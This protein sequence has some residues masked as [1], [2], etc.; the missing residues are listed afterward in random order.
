MCERV[1]KQSRSA[2]LFLRRKQETKLLLWVQKLNLYIC[3]CGIV[4]CGHFLGAEILSP[5]SPARVLTQSLFGR[6][7]VHNPSTNTEKYFSWQ[8]RVV[9]YFLH[10]CQPKFDQIQSKCLSRAW[11]V[12][13]ETKSTINE[14]LHIFFK[15]MSTF[16]P[17][18]FDTIA[19]YMQR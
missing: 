19:F 18:N 14:K 15:S 5:N 1:N 9:T 7:A 12:Q 17:I 3:V 13:Q 6:A 2:N 16:I 8:E 4:D 10:L 11:K